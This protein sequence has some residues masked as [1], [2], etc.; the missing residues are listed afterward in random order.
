MVKIDILDHD[1]YLAN[2]ELD[3]MKDKIKSAFKG[4]ELHG[5]LG[6]VIIRR[7]LCAE[8]KSTFDY[9]I[10]LN[11]KKIEIKTRVIDKIYK[12]MYCNI[13]LNKRLQF[14]DYYIFIAIMRDLSS[15][16]LM[17]AISKQE[18][19][20]K[21]KIIRKGEVYSNGKKC[22]TTSYIFNSKDLKTFKTMRDLHEQRS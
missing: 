9:D 11:G 22:K 18:M 6:E 21:S 15:A 5:F 10:I 16:Y 7:I 19:L 4:N 2:I 1:I 3:Q 13:F 12:D 20:L 17:G 8:K 14:T